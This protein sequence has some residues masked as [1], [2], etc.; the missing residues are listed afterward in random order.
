MVP[1][2]WEV[3]CCFLLC[4]FSGL[5]YV[6]STLGVLSEIF[7]LLNVFSLGVS[8]LDKPCYLGIVAYLLDICFLGIC[9]LGILLFL[10]VTFCLLDILCFL[11]VAA[12]QLDFLFGGVFVSSGPTKASTAGMNAGTG[13][14]YSSPTLC[15]FH[16]LRISVHSLFLCF[17][18]HFCLIPYLEAGLA[19]FSLFLGLHLATGGW[20][21]CM[22]GMFR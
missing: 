15:Q 10:G 3:L 21:H 9:L 12:C 5:T 2:H 19:C 11:G 18:L 8:L 17:D 4:C 13:G 16:V 22:R 20:S 1:N 6:V 7:A 14:S